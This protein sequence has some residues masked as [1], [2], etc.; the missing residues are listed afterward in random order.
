MLFFVC[1]VFWVG[2]CIVGVVCYCDFCGYV[3]VFVGYI[4]IMIGILVIVYLEGVFMVVLWWVLEI[5]L[6]IFCIGIVS[7][8]FLL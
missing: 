2:L 7:V 5:F 6:G 3:C 4:V 1:L 8:I